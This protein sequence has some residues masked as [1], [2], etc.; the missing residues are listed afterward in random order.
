MNTIVR[1]PA[2][3]LAGVE[4]L[5]TDTRSGALVWDDT[6]ADRLWDLR[7]HFRGTEYSGAFHAAYVA[8]ESLELA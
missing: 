6:V 5:I 3:I 7:R 4:D 2:D 8:Y 1:P